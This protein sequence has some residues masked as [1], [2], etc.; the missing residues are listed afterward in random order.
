MGFVPVPNVVQTNVR[1]TY[2][3]EQC[4]NTLYWETGTA[5]TPAIVGGIAAVL[6][7]Q[8]GTVVM[9]LLSQ[10]LT[11]REVY[12][13]GLDSASAP[14]ATATP[15]GGPIAGGVANPGLPGNVALCVSFRTALRGRSFRGRI[16]L[17]GI[18]EGM[19]VGNLIAEATATRI[20]NAV[21]TVALEVEDSWAPH[22][23]VSRYENNA[24]R[25]TGISTL[26]TSYG[27]SDLSVDSMRRRL[28]G[29]GN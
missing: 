4:E 7:N 12:A 29:R 22:C 10:D 9:P 6:L 18:T 11:L 14:S 19:V 2:F 26:V 5:T 1:Y 17:P 3:G 13:F 8:W 25:T 23:V 24:P 16:Y 27:V 21:N 20:V 15:G 28:P